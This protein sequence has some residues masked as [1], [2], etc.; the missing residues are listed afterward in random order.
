MIT[1][2]T[3]EQRVAHLEAELARV[4]SLLPAPSHEAEAD[5]FSN[6]LPFG[7]F[8]NDP[9]FDEILL[10]MREERELDA[11]NPAYT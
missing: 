6:D 1:T 3:I 10:G 11:D 5:P 4:A 9:Y 2:Q 7:V 8:A